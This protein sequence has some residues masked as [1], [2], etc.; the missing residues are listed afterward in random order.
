M[1]SKYWLLFGSFALAGAQTAA[2]SAK[3]HSCEETRTCARGGASGKGGAA[4]AGEAGADT[5]GGTAG[6][7]HGGSGGSAG[8]DA[9]A[10]EAGLA[11]D[12]GTGGTA[13][14]SNPDTEFEITAPTL[15]AGKTYVPFTGK[16]SA[17][18][19]AHYSWNITS[20]TLPAGLALQG[21]Q[22]ATLTI[23][24][25]PSEAGQFPLTFSV[26]DG[27]TT[28]SV[29]VTLVITHSALFLSDRNTPGAN[30]LFVTELGAASAATPVRLNASLPQ[31]GNIT[32]YAWSPD[33]SKVLY[34][35]TQSSGGASELWVASLATPGTAQRVSA[36]NV[37][38]SKMVWLAAGNIGAYITN[39]GDAYLVDLS[40][41]S[42]GASKLAVQGPGTPNALI[43]SPNGTSV[44][45]GISHDDS[46]NHISLQTATYVTWTPG[47]P[48]PVEIYTS[49][50]ADPF[51]YLSYDGRLGLATR[52]GLASY[53]DLSLASPIA[54][55]IPAG[56]SAHFA[57][58]P[59]TQALL[60]DTGGGASDSPMYLGVFEN[61]SLTATTLV[62]GC[63]PFS[64]SWS[65][66]GKNVLFG[67]K[68]GLRGISNVSPAVVGSDFFLLPSGFL[69]NTFTDLQSVG[70]SPDSKWIA[71]RADR[72]ADAQYD[73][74]LI[75]W[76]A[77]GVAHKPH[78]NAI[79]SGV[80]KWSFAPNSQIIA[81]VGT[82]APQSSTGLYL[83]KLPASG[84]P[85][86]AT[87]VSA[88][89][90]AVVQT[91]INWL[92]GSRL[93]TYR[94]LVAGAP[95]LFA[96]PVASDGTAGSAIPISG[97]SGTGVS[98]YQ[99]APTR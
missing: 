99:L 69:S 37:A 12:A 1:S 7:H 48:K 22:L 51:P 29:D 8:L 20:G 13:G 5:D 35:A 76:S 47:A 9:Q 14:D 25:T 26:T 70:W 42:P 21:A 50:F 2:C 57:W 55:S 87:L 32:S 11:E 90:S 83:T 59:N 89:A 46:T 77:P 44:I 66:D 49:G 4:D 36:A 39:T 16:L 95:Q 96:L 65:S 72:D 61:G 93:I 64:G 10:G 79:A 85:A 40:G 62:S 6:T 23:A 27:S 75:R 31:G 71:L 86:I 56:G 92:P 91:D 74:Q 80:T 97:V 28:K 30:E 63:T 84:A 98:S 24:G 18:G 81:F 38:V 82:I 45:V 94:A 67:C 54:N 60:F 17:S 68:T 43:Q 3:F 52:G 33:G 78:A 58:S 53:W 15:S 73:L 41:S 88:P 34:L 19:A